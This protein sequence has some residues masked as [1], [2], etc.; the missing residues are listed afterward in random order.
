MNLLVVYLLCAVWGVVAAHLVIW[1][2]LPY[3]AGML[4]AV[5]GSQLIYFGLR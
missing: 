3:W 2:G 1:R 5:I 4:I